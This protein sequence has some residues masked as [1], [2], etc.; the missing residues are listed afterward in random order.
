MKGCNVPLMEYEYDILFVFKPHFPSFEQ[1]TM[2]RN[3]YSYM[4]FGVAEIRIMH[5]Y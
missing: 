1:V 5:L 2:T 4:R 3:K